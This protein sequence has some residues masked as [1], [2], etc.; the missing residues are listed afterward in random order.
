MDQY[1]VVALNTAYLRVDLSG[2]VYGYPPGQDVEIPVYAA[3]VEG[4]GHR[5]LVDTGISDP[6]WF[7]EHVG[8]E[9]WQKPDETLLA[10]LGHLGWAPDDVSVVINTHLHSDHCGNNRLF[11]KAKVFVSSR[12][13]FFA[14]NPLP[15]QRS[16]YAEREFG[17]VPYLGYSLVNEDHYDVLPG[18]RVIQTHGHTPGHQSVLVNTAQGVLCIVGDAANAAENWEMW[19][20]GAILA[21]TTAALKSLAKIRR[22]ADRLLMAHDRDVRPYQDSDFPIVPRPAH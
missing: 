7:A 4:G 5:I 9:T 20:P 15:S 8:D 6:A 18:C 16:L 14:C 11:P 12:E 3:A 1:R 13:W 17:S 22:L 19:A 21:N 2:L 10:G